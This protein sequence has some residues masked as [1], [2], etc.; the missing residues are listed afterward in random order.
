MSQTSLRLE[1]L[2]DHWAEQLQQMLHTWPAALDTQI[3]CWLK[4]E[5]TR[6]LRAL[7]GSLE[8]LAEEILILSQKQDLMLSLEGCEA[9]LN[10]LHT[11]QTRILALRKRFQFFLEHLPFS[12]TEAGQQFLK[13]IWQTQSL[14][15]DSLQL[16]NESAFQLSLKSS[17]AWTGELPATQA[18]SPPEKLALLHAQQALAHTLHLYF[19]LRSLLLQRQR[20]LKAHQPLLQGDRAPFQQY[21]KQAIPQPESEPEM[22]WRLQ[23]SLDPPQVS[24]ALGIPLHFLGRSYHDYLKTGFYWLELTANQGFQ[25]P[26]QLILAAEAFYKALSVH[27]GSIEAYWALSCIFILLDCPRQALPYL[28]RALKREPHSLL[29]QLRESIAQNLEKELNLR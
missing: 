28:E 10:Q 24:N 1:I 16:N 7:A 26:E 13:R 15:W 25:S 19:V 12:A 4:Q 21:Q 14:L 18:L 5:R 8:E 11:L 27:A 23:I 22:A 29:Q 20:R 2:P 3:Q 6:L 17:S 9:L